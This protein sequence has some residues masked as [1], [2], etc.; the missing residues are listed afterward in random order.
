MIRTL[1][2]EELQ[3]IPDALLI[4]L[5]TSVEEVI[6]DLVEQRAVDFRRCLTGFPHPSGG[7]GHRVRQFAERPLQMQQAVGSW[8]KTAQILWTGNG[9]VLAR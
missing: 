1:L 4:S 9:S 7:N 8:F 5:G 6:T 2:V 3:L